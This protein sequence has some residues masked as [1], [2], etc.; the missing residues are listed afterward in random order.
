METQGILKYIKDYLGT[1]SD[2]EVQEIKELIDGSLNVTVKSDDPE[3]DG[4]CYYI[5]WE[6]VYEI[7]RNYYE[8]SI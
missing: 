1:D 4:E 6:K 8:N 3:F 5:H 2:M 7:N